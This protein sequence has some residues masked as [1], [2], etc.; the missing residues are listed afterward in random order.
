ML[1]GKNKNIRRFEITMHKAFGMNTRKACKHHTKI[2][3]ELILRQLL[4]L[5]DKVIQR[6]TGG[7]LQNQI[8]NAALAVVFGGDLVADELKDLRRAVEFGQDEG[9]FVE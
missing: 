2:P 5:V 4:A 9:F 8:V 6:P 1:R 3:F 7:V